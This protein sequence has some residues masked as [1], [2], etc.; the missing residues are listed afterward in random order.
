[1]GRKGMEISVS[2]LEREQLLSMSRSRSLP[3]SL[4]RRAKIIVMAADGHTSQE[5]A[6]RCEVTP[7]AITNWKK[8][9]VAQRL[10]GL[11]DEARPGRPR[12]HDDE[13]VAEL[14]ARVLHEKPDGAT[15][16]SVRSAATQTG[17]SKSSVARYLSLFGVQP[18]RS[19]C[20]KLS[21]D[22]YFV[23]KVRDIVGLYLSPPT[24]ALVLC[25]DEK[26]QCQ[27]L[28]RT[29]PVLP[30]G[31]GYLEG[32]THDYI[33]H[34]TTTLFAAL[35]TATDEVITQCKSRHRHQEFLAFLN[36]VDQAV[37]T[38]LEIHL[39][40]DNYATHKHPKVKA[41]LAKHRYHM[42]FTPTYSSWLN[43]VERW[44]GLVTQK[45]I[46]RGSFR[47]VRQ[48]IISIERYVQQ[49]N[50]HKRAF[51]WT[52]TAD[53]ILTKVAKLSKVISGTEH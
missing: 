40:V 25:V 45:A 33:R 4:V 21:T 9:F 27:A 43:Q 37:P 13:V 28:E 23:E 16:W 22:P 8:R 19:K 46:R 52:A 41:W 34:A 15:H 24:H 20:F 17:I 35:D 26:T 1:M 31:L 7:P 53:S 51:V 44:F 12:T 36:H 39:V 49:Y 5:I 38:D 11:H 47:N 29:Q 30:M 2:T 6:L 50:Q 10:A 42:H 14:L 3:H 48:L 32:V 18:H